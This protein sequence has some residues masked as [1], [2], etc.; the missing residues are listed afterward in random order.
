M[1]LMFLGPPGAG[2]G[3]IA[4]ET[5]VLLKVPH[6]S[7]GALFR[8]NIESGTSLGLRVRTIMQRGDLVP[9]EIT[10]AMVEERLEREDAR[11]GF[12]L[13][14]F[15]RTIPQAEA[16][17]RI[18][19]LDHVLNLI[20]GSD[21][22]IERLSGRRSCPRCGRIYNTVLM[23]PAVQGVCDDDGTEL[24]IREDD[25]VESVRRRLTVYTEA[26]APLIEWYRG[27]GLI[28]DINAERPPKGVFASVKE[29]LLSSQ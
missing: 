17:G 9:D 25:R 18:T 16:L 13:D 4:E 23:P 24:T 1:K 28:R 19:P 20:C 10:V 8:E 5:R 3:T 15:P 29:L 6:I 2:K 12:I 7:T 11:R 21:A 14:G 27:R 22:L 26:T